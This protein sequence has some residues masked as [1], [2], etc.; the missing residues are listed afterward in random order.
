MASNIASTASK[1]ASSQTTSVWS[2]LSSYPRSHPFIF[3][4][5]VSG[6]K[7]S[8]SDLLVQKVVEKREEV[9][10]K[11]NLAFATFGFVYLGG[12]QYALYVPIFGRIFPNAASFASKTFREKVKD[13]KG[14]RSLFGQVFLDQCVHHP[15]AYFPAF[16]CIKES[17]MSD[18]PD[19]KRT[20]LEYK[21]NLKEDLLALWKVWVPSALLNFAFMPMWARVPWVAGTS[22]VWTCILSAMRGGAVKDGK[23]L[24]GGGVDRA[25]M[26]IMTDGLREMRTSPVELDPSLSHICVAASGPDKVSRYSWFLLTG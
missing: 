25:T 21:S 14:V 20:L 18:K 11:R 13:G 7:T 23:A 24:A 1:V 3:G 10:W 9:D 15:L 4:V 5:V 8:F 26:Q 19:Y 22:L 12:V 2:L 16:Y 6:F 17:V